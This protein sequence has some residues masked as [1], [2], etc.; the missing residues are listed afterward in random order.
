MNR[1]GAELQASLTHKLKLSDDTDEVRVINHLALLPVSVISL[2]F[3]MFLSFE[4]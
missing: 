2:N 1:R 4:G 3:C